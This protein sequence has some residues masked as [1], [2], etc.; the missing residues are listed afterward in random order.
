M[1]PGTMHDICCLYQI[2]P[3]GEELQTPQQVVSARM[4]AL[5]EQALIFAPFLRKYVP[6]AVVTGD[7]TKMPMSSALG[8]LLS[9]GASGDGRGQVAVVVGD[10][11]TGKTSAGLWAVHEATEI[12]VVVDKRPAE[13]LGIKWGGDDG[14]ARIDAVKRGKAAHRAGVDGLIGR[15]VVRVAVAGE[16]RAGAPTRAP[17]WY[18]TVR[19]VGGGA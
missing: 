11:G 1:L 16:E 7:D 2:D 8:G 13:L 6:A 5:R 12:A 15:Y 18:R 4:L 19:A 10:G 3:R 14:A 9:S 17:P